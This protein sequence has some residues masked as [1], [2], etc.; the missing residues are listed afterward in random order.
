MTQRPIFLPGDAI[1]EAVREVMIPFTWVKGMAF[2]QQQKRA[3][4]LHEAAA[5]AG[6]QPVLEV[7]SKSRALEGTR[8]SAFLLQL[9]LPNGHKCSV[10]SAYQGSK[11]FEHGGPFS[12]LYYADSLDAK[13]DMRLKES[14][15]LRGFEFFGEEWAIQPASAFYDHLYMSALVAHPALTASLQEYAGFTDISFNP[16]KQVSCQARTVAMFV[17]LQKLGVE[18][19]YVASK[20]L[21]LSL[22]G[23]SPTGSAASRDLQYVADDE[24]FFQPDLFS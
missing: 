6:Y 12:D 18:K 1:N 14:G 17:C 11:V 21:F 16:K 2:S 7:S 8:L 10:E 23:A 4:A 9:T 13:R 15:A 24:E 20:E 19:E 22:Y 3:D 5:A